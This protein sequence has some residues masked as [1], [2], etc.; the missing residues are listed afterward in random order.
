M[1]VW[2]KILWLRLKIKFKYGKRLNDMKKDD[3]FIY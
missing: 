3:P 1:I 2:L